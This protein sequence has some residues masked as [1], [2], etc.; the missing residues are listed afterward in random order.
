MYALRMPFQHV[1]QGEQKK[2]MVAT[3]S[4]Y[5]ESRIPRFIFAGSKAQLEITTKETFFQSLL[6]SSP[7][8]PSSKSGC[9]V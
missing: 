3:P 9:N 6:S 7:I 5:L 1:F 2:K 4:S 8:Q